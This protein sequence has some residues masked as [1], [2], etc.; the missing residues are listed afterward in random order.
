MSVGIVQEQSI[1]FDAGIRL[2]SGRILAPVTLV[3]ETYGTLNA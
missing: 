1:T 2:E 3:Y